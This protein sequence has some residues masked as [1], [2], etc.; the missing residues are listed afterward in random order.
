M[1]GGR[2]VGEWRSCVRDGC[3]SSGG[4]IHCLALLAEIS[5]Y[6]DG[7][8]QK[9]GNVS[10]WCVTSTVVF[11]AEAYKKNKI[12]VDQRMNEIRFGV[13]VKVAIVDS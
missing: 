10:A 11:G 3:A 6:Q 9:E 4:L 12:L 1:G 13:L 8:V 7:F 5:I 2:F